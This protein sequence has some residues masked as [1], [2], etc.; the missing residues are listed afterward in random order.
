VPITTIHSFSTYKAKARAS[1]PRSNP[2]PDATACWPAP[3]LPLADAEAEPLADV[4]FELLVGV[5]FDV[6]EA[7]LADLVELDLSL[8]ELL[9]A[10]ALVAALSEALPVVLA[11]AADEETAAELAPVVL[12]EAA[13]EAAAEEAAVDAEPVPLVTSW[14]AVLEPTLLAQIPAPVW[15]DSSIAPTWP[16]SQQ[17]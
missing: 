3:E 15:A 7:L 1:P 14:A 4:P 10:A 6:A 16:A 8:E 9:V 11:T 2:N 17:K 13:V 12:A 5:A